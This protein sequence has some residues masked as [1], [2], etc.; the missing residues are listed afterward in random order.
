MTVEYQGNK[1]K[2]KIVHLIPSLEKGGQNACVWIS[3]EAYRMKV[4][5]SFWLFFERILKSS[6]NT[7]KELY[8][9]NEAQA[10]ISA[11]KEQKD[12]LLSSYSS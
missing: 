12:V 11:L 2:L 7:D 1:N 10:K 9:I 4:M 3:V 8:L 6:E 5:K